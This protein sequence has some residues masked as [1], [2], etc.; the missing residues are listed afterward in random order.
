MSDDGEFSISELRRKRAQ[1]QGANATP[2]G[3]PPARETRLAEP[4]VIE[5]V[6]RPP[7]ALTRPTPQPQ[8]S[9]PPS[10]Q[11]EEKPN[12]PFDLWRLPKALR[13]R[14]H[15]LA[16]SACL[17]GLLSGAAGFWQANYSI[18][19]PLTLRDLS[20]RFVPGEAEGV[21]FK[22][23]PVSTQALISFLTSPDLLGDVASQASPPISARQLLANL[24][25]RPEQNSEVLAVT[26]ASKDKAALVALAN[27]YTSAVVT[28]SKAAEQENPSLMFTNFTK[29]LASLERQQVELNQKLASFRN[30]SG[31]TDP[32][33]ENP[34]FEKEWVE[35]RVKI[36]IA[37]G[38]LD[39]LGTKEQLAQA[40]PVQKRLQEANAQLATFKSQ[41]KKNEHP[42]VKRLREEIAE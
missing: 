30:Q 9:Q 25:V 2:G 28:R 32:A 23:P 35:L 3:A 8:F 7:N 13:Q 5:T 14:W 6:R 11:L 31:V 22:P 20:S 15:W 38:Q 29:Q 16:F 42:E 19:I 34:A 17:L 36:D 12:L 24:S 4:T 40:E 39:L 26:I 41:G 33:I 1:S 37:R 21:S 18:H 27:L 10:P